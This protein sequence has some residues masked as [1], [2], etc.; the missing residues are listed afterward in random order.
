MN[1]NTGY[2]A[3]YSGSEALRLANT[4]AS[5]TGRRWRVRQVGHLWLAHET[6]QP[7]VLRKSQDDLNI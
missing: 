4:M 5:S 2:F 1:R 6:D 7:V 3:N